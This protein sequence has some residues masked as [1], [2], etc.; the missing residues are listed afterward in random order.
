MEECFISSLLTFIWSLL[1]LLSLLTFCLSVLFFLCFLVGGGEVEVVDE[2]EE[3]IE[4]AGGSAAWG[5][6]GGKEG[7]NK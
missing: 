4:E 6:R 2:V 5:E 7:D 3:D 1:L